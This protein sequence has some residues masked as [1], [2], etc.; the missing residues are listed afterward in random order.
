[1]DD[2]DTLPCKPEVRKSEKDLK[3]ILRNSD[4]KAK[5]LF[6]RKN[7]DRRAVEPREREL[8]PEP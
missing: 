5:D 7:S 3:A 1:M 4:E 2:Y 6:D 8:R